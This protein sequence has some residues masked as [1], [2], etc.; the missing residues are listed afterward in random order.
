MYNNKLFAW[1][2][3]ERLAQRALSLANKGVYV[4][5]SNAD[6]PNIH[7]LYPDFYKY[8]IARKS[9]IGG[10]G[11]NRGEITESIISSYQLKINCMEKI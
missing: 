5:I 1:A 11:S 10:R 6:H 9:L 8:R 3:Q 4:L 2:D 7:K